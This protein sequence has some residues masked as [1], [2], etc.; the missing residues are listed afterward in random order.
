MGPVEDALLH[1]G[2]GWVCH[3]HWCV[4]GIVTAI[5]RAQQI[6]GSFGL[7]EAATVF[8]IADSALLVSE[9][10]MKLRK[11]KRL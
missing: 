6:Q 7:G 11:N 9:Q 1:Q 8:C 3:S 10:Q 2:V 4:A 5:A